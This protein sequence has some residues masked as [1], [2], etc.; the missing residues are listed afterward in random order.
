MRSI[1]GGGYIN[2]ALLDVGRPWTRRHKMDTD[3]DGVNKHILPGLSI[4]PA[5]LLMREKGD[6][7]QISGLMAVRQLV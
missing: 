5:R 6:A 3:S 1:K 2:V 4:P 7:V